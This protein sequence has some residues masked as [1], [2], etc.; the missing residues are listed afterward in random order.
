[1]AKRNNK[2]VVILALVIVA[3]AVAV[4]KQ[5]EKKVQPAF[6]R[7]RLVK[8]VD[9]EK[10]A[11]VMIS[12]AA[13]SFTVARLSGEQWGVAS[14]DNYPADSGKVRALVNGTLNLE[15]V[16]QLTA[17]PEKYEQLGVGA[18]PS[19]AKVE[20]LDGAG[21]PL[22]TLYLGKEREGTPDPQMGWAPPMGQFVR[23]EG[24]PAVYASKDAMP[25]EKDPKQWLQR[26]ILKVEADS[27]QLVETDLTTTEGLILTRTGAE[28]FALQSKL[29]EKLE[30][31]TAMFGG[32][33][34]ALGNLT[35]TDAIT[36]GTT[37]AATLKFDAL[38]RATAK[39]GLIYEA[40][41]AEQDGKCFLRLSADYSKTAD[42]SLSD[43]RTSD[44]QMAKALA[45]ALDEMKKIN[46]RHGRWIY[47]IPKYSGDNLRRKLSEAVQLEGQKMEGPQPYV[48]SAGPAQPFPM[49]PR[50]PAKP[51]KK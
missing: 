50:Q 19:T 41:T 36:S 43:E 51:K 5:Q 3:S 39:N 1:M 46:E 10:V 9:I 17:N 28:P 48:S 6:A 16:E 12:D 40:R 2:V 22:T 23:L 8:N 49:E 14:R 20:L 44:T 26:E 42:F 21:K 7:Q 47:E 24:D 31:K 27:L 11:S 18:K 29:P 13:T 25:L 45:P 32:V 30:P 34:G 15:A 33:T 38:Y 37:A 35:L 4:Y